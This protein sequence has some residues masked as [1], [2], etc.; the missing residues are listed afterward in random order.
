MT[1]DNC[2]RR[3]YRRPRCSEPNFI[4]RLPRVAV[5]MYLQPV[6]YQL[7]LNRRTDHRPVGRLLAIDRLLRAV[8]PQKNLVR[9][10]PAGNDFGRQKV[11]LA[12]AQRQWHPI[13][14]SL[15][16]REQLVRSIDAEVQPLAEID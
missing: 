15:Q 3:R 4:D 2:P 8:N 12:I 1:S 6:E 16:M 14:N 5:D 9:I 10:A 11:R 13:T 7:A